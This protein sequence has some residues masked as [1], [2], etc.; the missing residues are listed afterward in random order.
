VSTDLAETASRQFAELQQSVATMYDG[1]DG[2]DADA[3]WDLTKRV[4][5]WA[6]D[7]SG[8]PGE[9]HGAYLVILNSALGDEDAEDRLR[10]IMQ[11]KGVVAIEPVEEDRA[12]QIAM[13]R[14]CSELSGALETV[15]APYWGKPRTHW[16]SR[17][18]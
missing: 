16:C 1:P 3:A 14:V 8:H 6:M 12:V 9:E 10:A 13:A 5:R 7:I 2:R 17:S 18:S 11:T 4:V 15:L